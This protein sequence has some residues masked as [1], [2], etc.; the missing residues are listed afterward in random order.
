MSDLH[1][2]IDDLDEAT[3]IPVGPTHFAI[4]DAAD[5]A[6][7]EAYKWYVLRGHTGKLYAYSQ[8]TYLHRL[9]AGTP[10]GYETDHINGNGLDNRR[11]NLRTASRSQNSANT[12]KPRRAGGC[13]SKY[14]GVS[15]RKGR[16]KWA[17]YIQVN[18]KTTNLGSF[19]SEADAA[20]AYDIAALAAWG[21]F[22]RL[23]FPEQ[24]GA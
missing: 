8:R 5:F 2:F 7:A 18:G 3:L 24:V 23:N 14:K 15:W 1:G 22:A 11:A 19:A 17:A 13:S 16:G 9:I 10:K 6:T 20:R 21:Q 12:W 4:V